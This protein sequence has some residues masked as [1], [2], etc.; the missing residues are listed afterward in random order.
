MCVKRE[1]QNFA[2]R[3]REHCLPCRWKKM[4]VSSLLIG[5]CI[6]AL[7]LLVKGRCS[8]RKT[9]GTT[10]ENKSGACGGGGG[11]KAMD[12]SRPAR[13]RRGRV[14]ACIAC[15]SD[16]CNAIATL[17]QNHVHNKITH[18]TLHSDPRACLALRRLVKGFFHVLG[19]Y[20]LFAR[21]GDSRMLM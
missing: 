1:P 8:Y 10:P 11:N 19:T 14:L 20:D 2:F 3:V 5:V 16:R 15:A 7:Q 21:V 4:T 6:L 17:C 9:A 18:Y 12:C 13:T